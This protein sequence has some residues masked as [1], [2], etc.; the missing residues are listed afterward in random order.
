LDKYTNR[1]M[2]QVV[3]FI[4]AKFPGIQDWDYLR[5]MPLLLVMQAL[6]SAHTNNR[7]RQFRQA[8]FHT[9]GRRHGTELCQ[10]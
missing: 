9:L 7:L 10:P 1:R 3:K 8:Y 6:W 5:V 4:A 2:I